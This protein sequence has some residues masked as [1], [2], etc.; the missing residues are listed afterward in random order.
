MRSRRFLQL[1]FK[2]P[3]Y[4]GHRTGGLTKEGI[5][6]T[7]RR[8]SLSPASKIKRKTIFVNIK[9]MRIDMILILRIKAWIEGIA[10]LPSSC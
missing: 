1:G 8:V 10:D 7:W 2:C 9:I 4:E 5:G 6:T 3:P